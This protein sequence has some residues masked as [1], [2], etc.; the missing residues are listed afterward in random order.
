MTDT[1]VRYTMFQQYRTISRDRDAL[2]PSL[3]R[4]FPA[5]DLDE[6]ISFSSLRTAARLSEH[7]VTEMVYVHSKMMI[8]DDK[9]AIIGSANI[10][11]RSMQG[12]RDSEIAVLLRDEASMRHVPSL[13]SII[14]DALLGVC[15]LAHGWQP[16][17]SWKIRP[18]APNVLVAGASGR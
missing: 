14:T 16:V 13:H 15:P 12:F 1:N 7:W 18:S 11:D 5:V 9:F 8:V 3:S 17:P 10:N 4:E 6:Y 2:L